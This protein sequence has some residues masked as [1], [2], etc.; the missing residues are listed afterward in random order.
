MAQG[1][2]PALESRLKAYDEFSSIRHHRARVHVVADITSKYGISSTT[3]Y[4]WYRG[5]T[6]W[7]KRAGRVSIVPELLYVLGALLGDG[8]IY[9]WRGVFQVWLVGDR[10]FVQ[11]YAMKLGRC[12][13]RNVPYYKYGSKNAWFVRVNNSERY[14]LLRDIRKNHGLLQDL[15]NRVGRNRGLLELVEGFFDAEGCVKAIKERQRKTAKICLDVCNTNLG[16]IKVMQLSIAE[17]LHIPSKISIQRPKP[18]RV[19]AYHLRIYKKTDVKRFLSIVPTTKLRES[20]RRL[21][22]VWFAKKGRWG[23]STLQLSRV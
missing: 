20:R 9:H 8:C 22:E 18:P 5:K 11:K 3:I 14:F 16:L 1:K 19:T 12:L 10:K 6:P 21:A 13:D 2:I 7:G 15:V 23:K 4:S 17:S